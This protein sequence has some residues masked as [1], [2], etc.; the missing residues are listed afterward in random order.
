MQNDKTRTNVV[1]IRRETNSV[2]YVFPPDSLTFTSQQHVRDFICSCPISIPC[3]VR[4]RNNF[5][6]R[7]KNVKNVVWSV[8]NVALVLDSEMALT[9]RPPG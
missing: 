9:A 1:T 4:K 8:V 6:E 5:R 2:Q 3:N 7:K